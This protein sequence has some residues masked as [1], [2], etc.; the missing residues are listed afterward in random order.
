MNANFGDD[1]RN[2]LRTLVAKIDLE[3]AQ[4]SPESPG[5]LRA[6][7]SE[8]VEA[9]AL[10]TTPETRVCPTCKGVGMRAASRCSK[11]WS[12]LAPL[13]SERTS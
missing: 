8:L 2:N 10:G 11:C 3:I 13:A 7:W 9:L 4:L 1:A 6:S 5:A 12:V